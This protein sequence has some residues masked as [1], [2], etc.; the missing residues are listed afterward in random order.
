[1]TM[2][3][4]M[5][6]GVAG[7]LL[8]VPADARG[9]VGLHWERLHVYHA[10]PSQ[11]FARLGLTHSTRYGYTLGQKRQPDPTFPPGLIDV[12]PYDLGHTLLVR[13]T[14]AGLAK[15]RQRVLAADVPEPCWQASLTLLQPNPDGGTAKILAGQTQEITAD[16]PLTVSFSFD[17]AL[18]QYQITVHVDPNG[19]L[20]VTHRVALS[21]A[22]APAV[23]EDAAGVYVPSQIWTRAAVDT[24]APDQT[25]TFTDRAADRDAARQQIGQPTGDTQG[26]YQ[27][28]MQLTPE[29]VTPEPVTPDPAPAAGATP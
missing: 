20:T 12:V 21:L 17:G 18:R 1:M 16:T 6:L 4:W 15:F 2:Q 27:V 22:P 7:L 23:T 24:L 11:V 14:A 13:G 3:K 29:P 28:Q 19:T 26:D 8:T 9:L 25:L 5:S 10:A